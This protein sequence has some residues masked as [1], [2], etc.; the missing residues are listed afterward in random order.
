MEM[1]SKL[2]LV[3][4]C[5]SNLSYKSKRLLCEDLR[6]MPHSRPSRHTSCEQTYQQATVA[7]SD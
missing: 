7:E 4:D 5:G 3:H 6:C 1:L 2:V